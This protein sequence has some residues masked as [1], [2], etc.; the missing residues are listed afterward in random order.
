[1]YGCSV[2]Y[3]N[4]LIILI[5]HSPPPPAIVVVTIQ[6]ANLAALAQPE[7]SASWRGVEACLFGIRAVGRDIPPDENEVT[8][9]VVA[10]LPK[11]PGHHIVRKTATLIVGK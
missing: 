9:R 1:M 5:P 6:L 8:P 11:V 4:S 3:A 10:L 2:S 7:L